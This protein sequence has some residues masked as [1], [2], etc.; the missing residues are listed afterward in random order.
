[1]EGAAA[2]KRFELMRHAIVRTKRGRIE[3]KCAPDLTLKR[4]RKLRSTMTLP[5]V[6]LWERF[7]G[8]RLNKLRF[9]RPHPKAPYI[10]NFYCASARLAGEIDGVNSIR[11]FR[12]EIF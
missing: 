4:T 3:S 1:M 10:P 12:R 8:G 7:P 9:G 6:L 2:H 5:E 11:V